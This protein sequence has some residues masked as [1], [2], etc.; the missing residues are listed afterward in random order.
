MDITSGHITLGN[1]TSCS[2]T[3]GP[4]TTSVIMYVDITTDDITL[5]HDI[6]F[7]DDL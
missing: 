3:S 4:I 7:D 2:M 5:W 1:K 6:L